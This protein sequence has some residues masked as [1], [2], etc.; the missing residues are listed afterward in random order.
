V[1]IDPNQA[2]SFF[3]SVDTLLAQSLGVQR[4]V[5]FLTGCFAVIALVLAVIGL[6]SVVAYAV[7]QRTGELGIRMA[8]GARPSQVLS[9]VMTGGLKLV[10]IGVVIGLAGAAGAARL[11]ATLLSNVT[12]LDPLVYASAAIVFSGVA[13]AACFVPSLRAARI[14]PLVALTN[15][16]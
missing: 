2:I 12:P 4:L 11:I 13:A 8:L 7:A 6:Y 15:K 9:L 5:A 10:A 14:D 3:Q 16:A 1:S